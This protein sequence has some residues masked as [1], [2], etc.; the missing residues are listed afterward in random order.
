MR[1]LSFDL[2]LP[3]TSAATLH[4]SC[5][6]AGAVQRVFQCDGD[7][8]PFNTLD[9]LRSFLENASP[10][11]GVSYADA[12]WGVGIKSAKQLASAETQTLV[13][14]GMKQAEAQHVKEKADAGKSFHLHLLCPHCAMYEMLGTIKL[15]SSL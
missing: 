6:G 12:L 5:L 14:S 9:D 11:Y 3:P 4:L 1:D 2:D 10:G 15:P 8:V 7:E 13:N